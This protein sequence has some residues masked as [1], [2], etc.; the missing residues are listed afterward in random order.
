ML[1]QKEFLDCAGT[2]LEQGSVRCNVPK[3]I[4]PTK[5]NPKHNALNNR[6]IIWI[7]SGGK[8]SL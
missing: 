5:Y 8:M 2:F 3:E 7:A 6:A 1:I 4:V